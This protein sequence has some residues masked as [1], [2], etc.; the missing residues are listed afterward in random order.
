MGRVNSLHFF[1]NWRQKLR[2]FTCKVLTLIDVRWHRTGVKRT[3]LF[4]VNRASALLR[5]DLEPAHWLG[6]TDLLDL[7]D[8]KLR[9]RANA[10][11]QLTK[12]EHER[13]L[14]IFAYV[15]ALLLAYRPRTRQDTPR[16][17][18]AARSGT[19]YGKSTLFVAL[20]RLAGIPARIRMVQLHGN[21][22]QGLYGGRNV[23][24]HPLVEVWLN[25]RWT[26]TDSHCFDAAYLEAARAALSQ[27]GW[28]R[29]YCIVGA[30]NNGWNGH[31]DAFCS[32]VLDNP[33]HMPLADFGV[34]ND[35]QEFLTAFGETLRTPAEGL[36]RGVHYRI[37]ATA[38]QHGIKKLRG[39][40]FTGQTATV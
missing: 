18:L 4:T 20:L 2:L 33:E 34:Y 32:L 24:N 26:R 13:A 25:S 38:M 21:L 7:D 31:A 15:K 11:T 3:S 19:T 29:G 39:A 1:R 37:A 40:G 17:V 28:D 36:W 14:A 6:S 10:L 12:N 27:Q 16:Q 22:L 8:D 5:A 23:V 35:T 9:M 30:A